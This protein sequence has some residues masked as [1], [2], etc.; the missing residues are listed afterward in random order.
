LEIDK[1]Y[2]LYP[3]D[4]NTG[5]AFTKDIFSQI[6]ITDNEFSD[7]KLVRKKATEGFNTHRQMTRDGIYAENYLPILIHKELD[8]VRTGYTWGNS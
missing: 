8:E 6:K 3:L 2:S 5:E 7:Q 4:K 1:N